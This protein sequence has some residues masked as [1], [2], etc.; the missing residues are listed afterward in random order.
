MTQET[1]TVTIEGTQIAVPKGTTIIEAAKQAGIVVP[2][3]CLPSVA[4]VP[5]RMPDV[6][7]R[8]RETT[9]AHAG[10]C[11]D[12]GGRAGGPGGEPQGQGRAPE[13]ARV[14]PHQSPARLPDLRPG[15]RVRAAGLR[16]PGGPLRHPLLR[17]RQALQ[18][19][20]G[21]RA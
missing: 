8:G 13:R 17:V 19:G 4:A 2:H 15:R 7:G 9:Q 11:D 1:V 14:S 16:V 18:P 3:Y 5:C 10:L 6:P 20:G 12:R 21:L